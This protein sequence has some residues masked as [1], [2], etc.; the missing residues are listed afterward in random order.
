MVSSRVF[1][2]SPGGV[3][4]TV[5]F[6]LDVGAPLSGSASAAESCKV[7][8]VNSLT[9]GDRDL[10]WVE[11]QVCCVKRIGLHSSDSGTTWGVGF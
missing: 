7:H 3:L 9:F 11:L 2:L 6:G 5:G 8:M 4:D 1:S 10:L